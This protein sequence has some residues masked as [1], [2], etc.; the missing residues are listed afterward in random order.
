MSGTNTNTQLRKPD[1]NYS[2]ALF[3]RYLGGVENR[4]R[5]TGSSLGIEWQPA[6]IPGRGRV[7]AF[8]QFV[9]RNGVRRIFATKGSRRL[10]AGLV[11]LTQSGRF[12]PLVSGYD[13]TTSKT[14]PSI[15]G[16]YQEAFGDIPIFD[17]RR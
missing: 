8:R 14:K 7:A 12:K 15:V 17:I 4:L 5:R 6:A 2:E 16:Y 10:D 11:D 9:D 3:K 13:I 1:P